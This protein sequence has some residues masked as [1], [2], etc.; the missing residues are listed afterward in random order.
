LP[1]F[2]RLTIVT[3]PQVIG[4]LQAALKE[5]GTGDRATIIEAPE[6]LNFLVWAEDP[7]VAVHDVAQDPPAIFLVE[8]YNFPRAGDAALADLAA[9]GTAIQGTQ[10]PLYFQGG[11][12]LVGDDFILIGA[13]YPARTLELIQRG[14][15][16]LVPPGND[17]AAF[18]RDLYRRTFDANREVIYVGTR[19]PVP[20]AQGRPVTIGGEE[21][22]E[23]LYVGT[24]TAQ[25]IFHIDMMISLAGRGA[26]GRYRLLVGSPSEADR[27]LD[28]PP[29]TH[30]MAEI[31]D[32]I[33][34]QLARQGFDV[35]RNPLPITFVDD[36]ELRERTWYF[37]TSN[38]ALVQIDDQTGMDVWLPTYGHGAWAELAP[39]DAANKRIW[40]DLGFTVHQ[41]ADF[42]PF[43]QGL[44]AVHC[45][46][47]Y[48]ER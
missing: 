26:D 24:G 30:A 15:P 13:D 37:A 39:S 10:S 9:E 41:L 5:A 42:N 4:D 17:P 23:W 28:R 6:F 38:N 1:S 12:I 3:H 14:T 16:I 21:W 32:D 8:P 20:Q 22:T 7:Y 29:V 34:R 11:N 19:L 18:V 47:K 25:P 27:I 43:A 46:K 33:A 2:T 31:F 48:L 35:I 36:P 45:I 40:E 44:G